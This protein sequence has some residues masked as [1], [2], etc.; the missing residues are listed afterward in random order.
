MASPAEIAER[1]ARH[2]RDATWLALKEA[3]ERPDCDTVP[4]VFSVDWKDP[5]WCA[6]DVTYATAGYR[7]LYGYD[8]R[9]GVLELWQ[10]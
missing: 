4:S 6:V 9:T 2:E 1:R 8:P 5:R 3:A 10:S 7:A